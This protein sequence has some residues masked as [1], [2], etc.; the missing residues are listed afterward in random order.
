MKKN[1][2]YIL[3]AILALIFL[4]SFSALCNQS[5]ATN[6]EKVAVNTS[7]ESSKASESNKEEKQD[8]N[9]NSENKEDNSDNQDNSQEEEEE[10]NSEAEAPT[11][12]LEIYEGPVYSAGDDVCYYRIKANVTGKPSPSITFSK[13]DSSGAWGS[14]KVQINLNDP[15]DSYTLTATATNSEGSASDSITL[16]WGCNRLPIIASIT[17]DGDPVY[18][19][20]THHVTV[21]ASD[22]D[23][24]NLAVTW[25]VSG[26][27]ID[28]AHANP[29]NWTTPAIA[30]NYDITV[31]V[32]DGKGGTVTLAK[33]I[34]VLPVLAPPIFNMD[35][36]H[37]AT[38]GGYL[39]N[40]GSTNNSVSLYAGD[41][42]SNRYC[43]G[44]ISYDISSLSGTTI[45]NAMLT[46]T[47]KHEWG[48]PS[49]YNYLYIGSLYWGAT[50]INQGLASTPSTAIQGFNVSGGGN[51]TC[52]SSKLV[53]ELQKAINN[54][55][56]RFQ[57]RIYFTGPNKNNNN[58]W[59]GWEYDQSQVVLNVTAYG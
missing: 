5:S 56:T 19:S 18:I 2:F 50:S 30:D 29:M 51:I 34:E 14:K 38:E 23:G 6:K 13:D 1:K 20:E 55:Q 35:V 42:N 37:V 39:E 52:T 44:Y 58:A 59:D 47:L 26:G 53:E 7:E 40:G 57:I 16:S 54:G 3:L 27:T 12:D 28:N 31:T 25:S 43:A 36:P 33:T 41:S 24:D 48:D 4:F 49:F 15:S 45:T 9:T 10:E 22:P 8:S 11:I 17:V 46:L 32:D 21:N